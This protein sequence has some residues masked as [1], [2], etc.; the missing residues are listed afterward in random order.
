MVGL[1]YLQLN[2]LL[3][4]PSLIPS[5]K[6]VYF[7]PL[8]KVLPYMYIIGDPTTKKTTTVTGTVQLTET[9]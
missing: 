8:C 6:P 2:T 9:L 3:H 5:P 4:L 7:Q 1:P